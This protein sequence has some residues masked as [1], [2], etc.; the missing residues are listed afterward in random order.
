MS[1][2]YYIFYQKQG[3]GKLRPV[4]RFQTGIPVGLNFGPVP[5]ASMPEIG[6]F[7]IYALTLFHKLPEVHTTKDM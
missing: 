2:K 3:N 5:V 7:W 1:V 4:D 6:C